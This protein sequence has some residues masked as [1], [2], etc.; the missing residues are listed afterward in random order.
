MLT[1]PPPTGGRTPRP[2]AGSLRVLAVVVLT[3]PLIL[4]VVALLPALIVCP[5]LS[6]RYQQ[7]VVR[8]LSTLRAWAS[9]TAA[10]VRVE[11]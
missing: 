7:H 5:F 2:S 11:T 10:A 4:V 3:V 6:L 8:L 1:D 9:S